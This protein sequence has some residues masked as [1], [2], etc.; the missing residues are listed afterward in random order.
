MF[1]STEPHPRILPV[2]RWIRTSYLRTTRCWPK[3]SGQAALRRPTA[4][5]HVRTTG[6]M[7]RG[8]LS[9]PEL[10]GSPSSTGTTSLACADR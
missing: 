3:I 4:D 7:T 5:L 6:R 2:Y 8:R 10:L 1:P 9:A